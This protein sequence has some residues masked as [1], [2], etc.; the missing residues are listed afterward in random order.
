MLTMRSELTDRISEIRLPQVRVCLSRKQRMENEMSGMTNDEYRAKMLE[1]REREVKAQ[2]DQARHLHN[3]SIAL[4][5]TIT[6]LVE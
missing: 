5:H 6:V 1:L 2:E 4:D 3:I